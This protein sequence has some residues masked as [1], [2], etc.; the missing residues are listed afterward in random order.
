[1]S[2][3][4][5]LET[6]EK[7]TSPSDSDRARHY[8]NLPFD[9]ITYIVS[10]VHNQRDLRSLSCVSKGF[11]HAVASSGKLVCKTICGLS[12]QNHTSYAKRQHDAFSHIRLSELRQIVSVPIGKERLTALNLT[13]IG[14]L[15]TSHTD[16]LDKIFSNSPVLRR[17]CVH[18]GS[19]HEDTLPSQDVFSL[20]ENHQVPVQD[21]LLFT[22]TDQ[23]PYTSADTVKL[24]TLPLQYLNDGTRWGYEFPFKH[25]HINLDLTEWVPA[26]SLNTHTP[27]SDAC[28]PLI[29][30]YCGRKAKLIIGDRNLPKLA[31]L[32]VGN[33]V[34]SE[35]ET[36]T[37]VFPALRT[38]LIASDS[39]MVQCTTGPKGIFCSVRH[40][41][42]TQVLPDE[43][44]TE[45]L[46][47][48]PY[49]LGGLDGLHKFTLLS[50]IVDPP[51]RRV[52]FSVFDNQDT[53]YVNEAF[54]QA[55]NLKEFNWWFENWTFD[56][57]QLNLDHAGLERVQVGY[58]GPN[59]Y[60]HILLQGP[61][62]TLYLC[63]SERTENCKIRVAGPEEVRISQREQV[64]VETI[65][66]GCMSPV[67]GY[68]EPNDDATLHK[69]L[70]G[71]DLL[72]GALK[73]V[74]L[75]SEHLDSCVKGVKSAQVTVNH[76]VLEEFRMLSCTNAYMSTCSMGW[77]NWAINNNE[78]FGLIF[79]TPSLRILQT[80]RCGSVHIEGSMLKLQE[81]QI[82]DTC[83][84]SHAQSH[85]HVRDMH[86][87]TD[88]WAPSL[89]I[90]C[91]YLRPN[92]D[93]DWRSFTVS[94]LQRLRELYVRHSPCAGLNEPVVL[95]PVEVVQLRNLPQLCDV[96]LG[97]GLAEHPG[98]EWQDVPV[99]DSVRIKKGKYQ[100]APMVVG[101]CE[102]ASSC[103]Y[104]NRIEVGEVRAKMYWSRDESYF[105][106][107]DDDEPNVHEN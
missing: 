1:M 107:D 90:L 82:W 106:Y 8:G 4:K 42:L 74:F 61:H 49:L 78:R 94:G 56:Y 52:L 75:I 14:V 44:M 97:P 45:S 59:L 88:Q 63:V 55:R 6:Y 28:L 91:L 51:K 7:P 32:S 86:S 57:F 36:Y 71:L 23:D 31:T 22:D 54:L 70:E 15:R 87:F 33:V 69:C 101:L 26:I 5:R 102:T 93:D 29:V 76:S 39:E 48:I 13:A 100:G 72:F 20:L 68:D 53:P 77:M 3:I 58:A 105:F 10:F 21:M 50:N 38:L 103:H 43:L 41:Y 99:L 92:Y 24:Q 66:L 65:I 25:Q 17:L 73:K 84:F 12:K 34:A 83:A 81:I 40:L 46:V 19:S 60:P 18:I 9:I 96:Y 95:F 79:K 85:D 62:G 64:C 104:I 27:S 98:L 35:S 11:M 16:V 47:R 30:L 89:R 67:W 37:A 2:S 80:E